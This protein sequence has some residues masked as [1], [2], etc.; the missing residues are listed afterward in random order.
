MATTPRRTPATASGVA[1]GHD[2]A[3][4][5]RDGIRRRDNP[6]CGLPQNRT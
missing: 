6:V 5:A 4:D 3:A 2:A 1:D